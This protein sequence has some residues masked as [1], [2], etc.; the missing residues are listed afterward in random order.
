MLCDRLDLRARPSCDVCRDLADGRAVCV[1]GY[2]EGLDRVRLLTWLLPRSSASWP[3]LVRNLAEASARQWFAALVNRAGVDAARRRFGRLALARDARAHGR[4]RGRRDPVHPG[5][6]CQF[7]LRAI[8]LAVLG[9][10]DVV[11]LP[12]DDRRVHVHAAAGGRVGLAVGLLRVRRRGRAALGRLAAARPRRAPLADRLP[13]RRV[14]GGRRRRDGA[15]A[16]H[17][18]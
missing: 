15:A 5:H 11:A 2:D 9:H 17:F 8:P 7:R 12:G 4:G 13:A 14:R 18:P 6:R 1:H 10:L 3:R 16:A